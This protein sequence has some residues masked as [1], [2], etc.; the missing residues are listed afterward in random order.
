PPQA[1]A[2]AQPWVSSR[3]PTPATNG[4][5]HAPAGTG[6]GCVNGN[7][8]FGAMILPP[9]DQ[10]GVMQRLVAIPSRFT[11]PEHYRST[12]VSAMVEEINLRLCE[13]VQP[14][15]GIVRGLLSSTAP[16]TAGGGRQG[17]GMQPRQGFAQQGVGAAAL[18][19]QRPAGNA[20][21]A[22]EATGGFSRLPPLAQAA[23]LER[24]CQRVH[25]PYFASCTLTCWVNREWAGGGGGGGGGKKNRKRGCGA[26]VEE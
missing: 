19:V 24:A 1:G 13:S 18:K 26:A 25:V 17:G 8:G 6:A 7:I 2:L 9:L 4:H 12:L 5:G 10:P 11:G 15:Y 22:A 21:A 16:M 23:E 3:P 14:L 20:T